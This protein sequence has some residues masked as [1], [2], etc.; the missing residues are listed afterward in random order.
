MLFRSLTENLD[1][2]KKLIENYYNEHKDELKEKL[3]KYKYTFKKQ[4]SNYILIKYEV[5][6]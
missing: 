6:K 2:N 4:D 5:L 1:E 3:T